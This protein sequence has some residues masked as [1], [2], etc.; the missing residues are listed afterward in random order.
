MRL[1]PSLRTMTSPLLTEALTKT[2]DW[3]IIVAGK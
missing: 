2:E 1:I 3:G